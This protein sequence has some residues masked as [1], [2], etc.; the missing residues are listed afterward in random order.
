M[1]SRVP[2]KQPLVSMGQDGD[3][4]TCSGTA[5]TEPL[6]KT[7]LRAVLLASCEQTSGSIHGI[8][9]KA[10]SP[11]PVPTLQLALPHLGLKSLVIWEKE[12]RQALIKRE[13]RKRPWPLLPSLTEA[14]FII[15]KVKS[16][17]PRLGRKPIPR[18][19]QHLF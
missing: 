19:S 8:F 14:I 2:A 3:S 11:A 13:Q 10:R 9:S 5:R 4:A 7:K 12:P 1:E 6:S 16:V 18:G 15:L 17:G